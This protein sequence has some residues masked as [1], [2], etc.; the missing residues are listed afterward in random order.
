M[1]KRKLMVLVVLAVLGL[2]LNSCTVF[3]KNMKTP[4]YRVEFEKDDFE[5]SNQLAASAT[6]VR[7]LGIDW[8]RLLNWKTGNIENDGVTGMLN[9]MMP[10][11]GS[12]HKGKVSS[13]ALYNLMLENPGY[14]VI[15][16]P[17]FEH[18]CFIVPILYSKRTVKVK[19]R[20]G[21]IK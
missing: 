7:V 13:Y 17:Q 5:F 19:A 6:S 10:V 4:N 12:Y 18:K 16:Y 9:T 21:R 2:S 20:L 15:I 14:D 3:N 8:Q 1:R 11:I